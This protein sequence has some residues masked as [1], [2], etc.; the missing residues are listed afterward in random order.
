[1]EGWMRFV[2]KEKLKRLKFFLKD[3]SK[4][5]YG[6][7]EGRI[8]GLVLDISALDS[9]GEVS[10]LSNQEVASTSRKGKFE[11]LWCFL[12]C[13]EALIFQRSRS[14]WLKDGDGNTNFFHGCI[15]AR[16]RLNSI[17]ALRVDDRWVEAHSL[18][19]E[20]VFS[21]FENHVTSTPRVRP[22]LDNAIFPSISDLENVGLTSP[23]TMEEIEEVVKQS[24]GNKSPG[25]D[26]FNFAFLK[27]FWDM[28]KGDVRMMFDQFHGNACLPKSLLSY[29]VALIPKV[30]SPFSL[31]DFRPI[32]LLGCLYKLIAKVLAKRLDK[33]MDPII[34]SNQSAF[35]KGRNLVDGVVVVNEV[36]EAAKK[37]R[38]DCLIFKVD[39]EKAYDSVEWGF[40]EYMLHRFGFCE[41]WIQWI[42]ACVFAGSLSVLVNGSP[43][44]EINI[45]RGLK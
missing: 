9:R 21:Y 44:F 34:A 20:A 4:E 6:G 22:K 33:V 18:I 40:L 13:K 41:K 17:A 28:I 7:L 23:F 1:V 2:L 14:K 35:L 16:S 3:W 36:V 26:G 29:F 25:P 19:K 10:G 8:N 15:K 45:Q 31:T 32:S 38:K 11:E 5:E 30:N 42:Q 39:F 43:T 37:K 12:K 24:D 27:K